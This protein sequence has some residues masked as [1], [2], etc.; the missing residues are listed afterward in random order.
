[1]P[2]TR[3]GQAQTLSLAMI[4]PAFLRAMLA[5]T[6]YA[7]GGNSPAQRQRAAWAQRFFYAQGLNPRLN[8]GLSPPTKAALLALL[9]LRREC[10]QDAV[11]AQTGAPVT[12]RNTNALMARLR[13]APLSDAVAYLKRTFG[14]RTANGIVPIPLRID[15]AEMRTSARNQLETCT[16]LTQA[17]TMLRNDLVNADNA[18]AAAGRPKRYE[19]AALRPLADADFNDYDVA[20]AALD[21]GLPSNIYDSI[22]A[23]LIAPPS[24]ALIYGTLPPEFPPGADP[25]NPFGDFVP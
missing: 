15:M 4:T 13:G 21:V 17:T 16:N 5:L 20:W 8:E 11:N 23:A 18:E 2:L 10:Q 9:D 14:A 19:N 1:M 7:G 25:T 24:D 6:D 12:Y 3:P 22:S